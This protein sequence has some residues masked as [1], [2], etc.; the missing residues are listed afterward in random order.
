MSINFGRD[1]TRSTVHRI[2]EFG[3]VQQQHWARGVTPVTE[4]YQGVLIEWLLS[5]MGRHCFDCSAVHHEAQAFVPSVPFW[6]L[7]DQIASFIFQTSHIPYRDQN[8]G[9]PTP[10]N[11]IILLTFYPLAS[12][13]S[14]PLLL[15]GR[16]S[17]SGVCL[18][19][20]VPTLYLVPSSVVYVLRDRGALP[21]KPGRGPTTTK[22]SCA[23]ERC[24]PGEVDR[25]TD[26]LV[27]LRNV[28]G[29]R[30]L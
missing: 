11:A 8:P 5:L 29:Q 13:S 20:G 30:L 12:K 26:T 6:R 24:R 18:W 15:V 25:P 27:C 22:Q 10:F 23:W 17:R 3:G 28:P 2:Q 19:N 4:H 16:I 21:H 1:A 7:L 9:S 14:R